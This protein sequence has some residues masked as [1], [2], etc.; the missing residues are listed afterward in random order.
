MIEFTHTYLCI[1]Q[2]KRL[3]EDNNTLKQTLDTAEAAIQK[4]KSIANIRLLC[5]CTISAGD[6]L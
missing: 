5:V 4:N 6:T 2:V 3:S 1:E